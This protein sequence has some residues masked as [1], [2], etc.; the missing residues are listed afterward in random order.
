MPERG[1]VAVKVGGREILVQ[2]PDLRYTLYVE[3]VLTQDIGSDNVA[4][5]TV[6]AFIASLPAG[7]PAM[8]FGYLPNKQGD[9]RQTTASRL[10]PNVHLALQFLIR[11]Y[12]PSR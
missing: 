9:L 12:L 4:L 7:Q 10:S 6:L 8:T 5:K 11:N 1:H 3:A 2:Y